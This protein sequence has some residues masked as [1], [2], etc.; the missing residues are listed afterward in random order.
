MVARD[1]LDGRRGAGDAGGRTPE[2]LQAQ[3][4]GI[5]TF[6]EGAGG[7]FVCWAIGAVI[8]YVWKRGHDQTAALS[9]A[10]AAQA[11]TAREIR[12]ATAQ[13]LNKGSK[14]SEEHGAAPKKPA[15]Q[16]EEPE[17]YRL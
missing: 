17:V 9:K 2:E 6:L 4:A 11:A 15:A 8:N 14:P 12:L 5:K 7:A 10:A 3:G 1:E 13:V 16:A